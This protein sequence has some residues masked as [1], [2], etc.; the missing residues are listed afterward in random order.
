MADALAIAAGVAAILS[1]LTVVNGVLF[2]EEFR[3]LS[4]T[5]G[6]QVASVIS[7]LYRNTASE[8]ARIE[9]VVLQGDDQEALLFR[10]S[11]A[12]ECNMTAVAVSDL[13]L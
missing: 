3:A 1:T 4:K 13:I 6:Y 8:Y 12:T 5:Y 7:L 9:K 11:V 2:R 10:S